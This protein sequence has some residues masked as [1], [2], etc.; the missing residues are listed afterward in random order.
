MKYFVSGCMYS[1]LNECFVVSCRWGVPSARL[2]LF[3]C[4]YVVNIL[5]ILI[6]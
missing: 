1:V 4:E 6:F 3:V 5:M 2:G